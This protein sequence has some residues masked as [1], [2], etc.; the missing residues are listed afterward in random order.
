MV[1]TW[2][3]FRFVGDRT[4]DAGAARGDKSRGD[5]RTE[6]AIGPMVGLQGGAD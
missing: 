1:S 5:D 2:S 4:K 3:R 6:G